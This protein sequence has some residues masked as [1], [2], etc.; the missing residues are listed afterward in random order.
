[1]GMRRE[2]SIFAI[3]FLILGNIPILSATDDQEGTRRAPE[4]ASETRKAIEGAYERIVEGFKKDDPSVWEGFLTPDF[5]LKLFSGEEKDRQWVLGYVRNNAKAFKVLELSMTVK[6]LTIRGSDAIA[7]VE[8][9]SSRQFKDEEGKEH[10]L[11]VGVI[12]QET[13]T[14]SAD[15]WKLREVQ[16]KEV[17]YLKK[18]GKPMNQ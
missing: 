8:Q 18:D 3:A 2:I 15:G 9:K 13:W 5:R 17:L 6:E 16:E 4:G 11:E 10:K 7:I 14:K 12:Q 1:M